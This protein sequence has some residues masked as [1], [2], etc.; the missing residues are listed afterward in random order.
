MCTC[1]EKIEEWITKYSSWKHFVFAT[2]QKRFEDLLN[3]IDDVVFHKLDERLIKLLQRK[4]KQSG[5][6]IFN[7][8]HEELANELATSRE[9]TLGF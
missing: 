9:A 3:V 1:P 5:N 6:N 2:Y 7:I 4:A 8:T